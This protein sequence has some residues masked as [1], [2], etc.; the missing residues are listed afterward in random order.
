MRSLH[1]HLSAGAAA[2]AAAL[3]LALAVLL[4]LAAQSARA[5]ML[6][7]QEPQQPG[8]VAAPAPAA[9]AAAF[10]VMDAASGRILLGSNADARLQVGSLTK[11][12]TAM[13]VLDWLD[14][15]KRSADQMATVPPDA[16]ALGGQNPVGFQPGDQATVRDLLYAALL[17]SDN[18]AALTLATHV[19][20][21]LESPGGNPEKSTPEIRFVAQM[22]ALARRLR[23]A[24][25][26]FTNP[27]GLEGNERKLPYSTAADLA[28]LTR[29]AEEKSQFR[30]Y[31]SQKER[32]ITIVHPDGEPTQY[33]LQNTNEL[34]GT[35]GIDG[36]KTG[37][38]RRAGDCV[39][40]SAARAPESIQ[41][42][43]KY[44]I[45]P[46]RLIVVVL[47]A[48]SR[49]DIAANLLRR[50]WQAHESWVAQGRPMPPAADSP[51]R[52]R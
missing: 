23:M 46:R 43:S 15:T 30:F 19:G 52:R 44:I 5:Q 13:V 47:G 32:V 12:A 17:Q 3:A 51:R 29:Y 6:M 9:A 48:Q 36:V 1:K 45:T 7:Q 37:R 16:A 4:C 50:G 20:R 33:Q 24:N 49:F 40:I 25:T 27:H 21:Q 31:V 22:N 2:A 10:A 18:I 41:Q 38:T 42:G 35:D 34:L 8:P 26:L 11:V 39:I 28:R 14:L